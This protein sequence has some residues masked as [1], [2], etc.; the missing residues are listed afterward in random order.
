ML[1]RILGIAS[2]LAMWCGC[3]GEPMR[4][5]LGSDGC[6]VAGDAGN[7]PTD[8]ITDGIVALWDGIDNAGFGIHD[9]D[10]IAWT[11]C[12]GGNQIV[13]KARAYFDD[14]SVYVY[15]KDYQSFAGE[16]TF[17]NGTQT[18]ESLASGIFTIEI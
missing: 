8:Y 16:C 12:I 5:M 17:D 2:V 14:D 3:M 6:E 18:E 7:Y 9:L 10:A 15:Y 11:D 1:R 13:L 4:S